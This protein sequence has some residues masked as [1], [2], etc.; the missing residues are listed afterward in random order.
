[1]Q[2]FC[3]AN[4]LVTI[5]LT[6]KA[7]DQLR[8]LEAAVI[9]L[10]NQALLYG[11]VHLVTNAE[12]GWVEVSAEKFLPGVVPLLPKVN[13]VSARSS[14]QTLYPD[15]P[16]MWKVEAFRSGLEQVFQDRLD[17]EEKSSSC[18]GAA[19]RNVISLGDSMHERLA[20]KRVTSTMSHTYSKSV[21]FVERPTVQQLE[22]ELSIITGSFEYL[23][24]YSGNLDLML[25]VEMLEN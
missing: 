15:Q 18:N 24:T 9:K 19:Y 25:V 23:C 8:V 17:E 7:V 16:S 21:K 1:M 10:L 20:L 14:Y 13:I 5:N 3:L 6:F 12:T 22:R 4:A 2:L 11:E